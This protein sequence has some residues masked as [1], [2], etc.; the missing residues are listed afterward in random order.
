[1]KLRIYDP[2]VLAIDI[3]HRRFGYALFEGHG[4]ILDWGQRVYPTVGDAE[5]AL[6]QK[7]LSKLMAVRQPNL[8]VVRRERWER[9]VSDSNLTNPV[10]AVRSEAEARSIP[11]YL[12]DQDAIQTTF[13]R[14]ECETR[15]DIAAA[16]AS[17]FPELLRSLPPKRKPWKAEHPRMSIFDA[18][19]LGVAYWHFAREHIIVDRRA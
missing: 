9:A 17:I 11:I 12:I 10:M 15:E 2:V 7:R 16:L 3:R 18:V 19:A 6:A 8:I 13:S 1:M 4:I 14:F 5:R